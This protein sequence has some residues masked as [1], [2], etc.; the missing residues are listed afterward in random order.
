MLKRPFTKQTPVHVKS[1]GEIRD[2]W[3]IPNHKKGNIQQ[4]NGQDQIKWRET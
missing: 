1:L 2:T 3:P 4:T